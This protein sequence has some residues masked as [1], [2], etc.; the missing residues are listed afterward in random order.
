MADANEAGPGPVQT[1]EY[2]P[3]FTRLLPQTCELLQSANLVVH[4]SVSRI[5]LHGSRGLAG[6]S[7]DDSDMD[8]CL[9]IDA[10]DETDGSGLETLLCAVLDTTFHH[11]RSPVDLDL[12]AVL[13]KKNCGL[14]CFDVTICDERLCR[15]CEV[16]CFGVYKLQK[17]C[18]GIVTGLGVEVRQM[19]PCLTIWRN[20]SQ[21]D[22]SS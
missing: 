5:T 12:A 6:G 9:I 1:Q 14:T 15:I 19:Y 20:R 3:E 13:D 21:P 18:S 11:W 17:G 7:R 16:D 22:P 10:Q 2:E 4:P 8:L